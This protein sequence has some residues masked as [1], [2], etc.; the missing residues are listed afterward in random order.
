MSLLGVN[1]AIRARLRGEP[2]DSSG[3]SKAKAGVLIPNLDKANK[4]ASQSGE[5]SWQPKFDGTF[6]QVP[7]FGY[8]DDGQQWKSITPCVVFRR[9]GFEF[10]A[11]QSPFRRY[12]TVG[13]AGTTVSVLGRGGVVAATGKRYNTT[14]RKPDAYDHVYQ[15]DIW[16][17]NDVER[18]LILEAVLKV[19]PNR[20][21]LEYKQADLS[22][23]SVDMLQEDVT[24]SDEPVG[25]IEDRQ[26]CHTVLTYRVEAFED[27][28]LPLTNIPAIIEATLETR[29]S[30]DPDNTSLPARTSIFNNKVE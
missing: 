7:V 22:S 15:L 23:L 21:Y 18:G 30:T 4:Q 13:T 20:T 26:G 9:I 3:R 10:N 28:S 5:G 25:E 24:D 14:V 6:R 27:T 8:K 2:V 29:N 12:V 11:E 16:A 19:F 17:E 1:R